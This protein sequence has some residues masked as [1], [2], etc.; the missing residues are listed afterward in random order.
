MNVPI[1]NQQLHI[2]ASHVYKHTYLNEL[3][4]APYNKAAGLV[5]WLKYGR[6]VIVIRKLAPM[7]RKPSYHIMFGVLFDS[8]SLIFHCWQLEHSNSLKRV[9]GANMWLITETCPGSWKRQ[10]VYSKQTYV[11]FGR[12]PTLC[13]YTLYIHWIDQEYNNYF[14][15]ITFE[16]F[17]LRISSVCKQQEVYK[18]NK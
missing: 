12:T 2:N 8:F 11:N 1:I 5:S 16:M 13:I 14:F 4:G 7:V 9:S 10:C 18:V 3:R 17:G 6:V 15:C